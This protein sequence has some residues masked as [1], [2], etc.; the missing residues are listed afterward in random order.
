MIH[1]T[2]SIPSSG[3]K[4]ALRSC[5]EGKAFIRGRGQKKKVSSK[6]WIVSV[7]VTFLWGKAGVY[8]ADYLM[9]PTK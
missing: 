1:E 7:K 4:G 3:E 8:Q 9:M 6:E 2:S 5:T